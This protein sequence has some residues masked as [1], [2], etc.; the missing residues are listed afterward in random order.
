MAGELHRVDFHRDLRRPD[1][2]LERRLGVLDRCEV[3]RRRQVDQLDPVGHDLT[4]LEAPF[5]QTQPRD[6]VRDHARRPPG[7]HPPRILDVTHHLGRVELHAPGRQQLGEFRVLPSTAERGVGHLPDFR[8]RIEERQQPPAAQH[9]LVDRVRRLLR[10]R[11]RMDQHQH[12]DRRRDRLL[13]HRQHLD[14]E[15]LL[16]LA[17]DHPRLHLLPLHRHAAVDLHARDDPDLGLLRVRELVDELR[18]VIFE[19][20]LALRREEGNHLLVVRAVGRHKPEVA[21]LALRAEP[22]AGKPRRHRPVLGIRERFGIDERD[23]ELAAGQSL[24]ALEQPPHPVE[25]ALVLR[26][27]LAEALR[28]IDLHVDRFLDLGQHPLGPVRDR[29]KLRRRQVR[30]RVLEHRGRYDV[31]RQQDEARQ[32]DADPGQRPRPP[33]LRQRGDLA[34]RQQDVAADLVEPVHGFRPGW[35]GLLVLLG[36]LPLLTRLSSVR[37][38]ACSRTGRK[39]SAKDRRS[40]TAAR[41]GRA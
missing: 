16:D 30:R 1:E 40:A 13:A 19:E 9:E 38:R 5:R 17:H 3:A 31:H 20:A 39:R 33:A 4:A 37:P 6:V 23:V 27:D 29:I 15:E 18:H 28:E 32:R 34:R 35:V 26:R 10:Q 21:L 22:D 12:V 2:R 24:V 14:V 41:S 11:D 7:L 36:H 8:K 25:I